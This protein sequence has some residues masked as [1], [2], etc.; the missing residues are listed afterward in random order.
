MRSIVFTIFL[1]ILVGCSTAAE[2]KRV[3]RAVMEE[4]NS[5]QAV[6]NDSTTNE[7]MSEHHETG[8]IMIVD[9]PV[10][11]PAEDRKL[12]VSGPS[13]GLCCDDDGW[14]C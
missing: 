14:H 1:A 2:T 3:R 7:A 12:E 11:A 6:I 8:A 4:K 9:E 10:S 13:C 5:P